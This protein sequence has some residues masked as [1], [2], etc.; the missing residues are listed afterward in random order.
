MCH[1]CKHRI[2]KIEGRDA[3][4][5]FP[6]KIPDEIYSK[7]FDHRK[8]YPEDKGIRFKAINKNAA[9]HVSE[10]YKEAGL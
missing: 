10:L 5:A 3:C 4:K 2:V 6:D 7:Y 1:F 8:E 9:E